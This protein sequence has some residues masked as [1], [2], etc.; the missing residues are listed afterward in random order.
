[1]TRRKVTSLAVPALALLVAGCASQQAA[2]RPA[3]TTT[4]EA[5]YP[6]TLYNVTMDSQRLAIVRVYSQGAYTTPDGRTVIEIDMRIRNLADGPMNL[7]ISRCDIDADAREGEQ[8]L[9]QP[10]EA[11]SVAPIPAGGFGRIALRYPLQGRV[12]PDDITNFDF[13][14]T[15]DTGKGTY[16][17]TTAFVQ[18]MV[19]NAYVYYPIYSGWWGYPWG[20]PG[21]GWYG[22]FGGGVE[23]GHEGHEE[24]G[25]ERGGEGGGERGGG[26]R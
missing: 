13:D 6:A 20:Y 7:D 2:F 21:W 26:R 14:W 19:N 22:G 10:L 1:M 12:A 16:A 4:Y 24:H 17:N 18:R 15:L 23:G 8:V 3:Q 25:G 5:G 9:S 11:T